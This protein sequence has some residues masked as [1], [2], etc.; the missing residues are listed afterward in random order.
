MAFF[1]RLADKSFRADQNGKIVF[2]PWGYFG[3]GYILVD[4]AQEE[5]IR[6]S[7]I[8]GNIVGLS[9]VFLIGVILKLWIVAFLLFPIV[10]V[11]WSILVKKY[12]R[13]LEISEMEYSNAEA[14]AVRLDNSIRAL[15]I[16]IIVQWVLIVAA[17]VFGIYEERY[18]PAVLRSYLN[19]QDSKPLSS[20]EIVVLGSALFFVL[21]LIVTSIGLYRLKR[22]ART[23]Y[24]VCSVFGTVL[25]LFM[26]PSVTPPIEGTIEYVANATEGFTIA[27]LYFSSAREY[28]ENSNQ[29]L[30]EG[31]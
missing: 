26:G 1:S 22:W 6:R 19:E 27:L 5:K 12:T 2:F 9:L 31:R 3:K 10:I 17:I 14:A 25:F 18:L 24:V 23:A 21:G 4:K 29:P 8:K 11:I 15:R 30:R 28:F 16:S 20:G 7:I 13:G